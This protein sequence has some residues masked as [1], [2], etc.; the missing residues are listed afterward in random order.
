MGPEGA[1][2]RWVS[3]PKDKRLR[4]GIVSLASLTASATLF[5]YFGFRA[6]RDPAIVVIGVVLYIFLFAFLVN[7]MLS[8]T[9][10]VARFKRILV[11]CALAGLIAYL[12]F[13]GF[14]LVK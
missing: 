5:T 2:N 7:L 11:G 4:L 1:S 10:A 9:G 12:V 13:L 6:T 3:I 14:M 8:P